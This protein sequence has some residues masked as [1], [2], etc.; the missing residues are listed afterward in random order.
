MIKNLLYRIWKFLFYNK[1]SVSIYTNTRKSELTVKEIAERMKPIE[2][3]NESKFPLEFARKV[4]EILREE[5][6]KE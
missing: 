4:S 6:E 2:N 1:P 3:M 5:G